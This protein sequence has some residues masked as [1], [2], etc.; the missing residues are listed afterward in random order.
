MLVGKTWRPN[1]RT[2]ASGS[3][4]KGGRTMR[5]WNPTPRFPRTSQDLQQ[6]TVSAALTVEFESGFTLFLIII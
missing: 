2:F 4:F 3:A 6:A 5:G 1:L